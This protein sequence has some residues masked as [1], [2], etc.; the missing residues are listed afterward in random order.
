[1]LLLFVSVSLT[2]QVVAS[3]TSSQKVDPASDA[4]PCKLPEE[5][6]FPGKHSYGDIIC[7]AIEQYSI[8]FASVKDAVTKAVDVL[9]STSQ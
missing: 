3:A 5:E 6:D 4:P 1:M 7:T 8:P 9:E 2:S